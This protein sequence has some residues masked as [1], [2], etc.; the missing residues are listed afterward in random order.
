LEALGG[1]DF[2]HGAPRGGFYLFPRITGLARRLGRDGEPSPSEAVTRFLMD[3]CGIAVVPGNVYGASG[4]GHV[5][6][7]IAAP[8]AMLD[9]ALTRMRSVLGLPEGVAG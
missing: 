9:A 6:L 3:K 1:F 7:V 4:E 8:D 5:R 2:P